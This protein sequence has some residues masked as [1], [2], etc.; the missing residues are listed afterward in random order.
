MMEIGNFCSDPTP[1]GKCFNEER[2]HFGMWCIVSSPLV[3]GFNMSDQDRMNRVWPIITNREAIAVDHAWA[4]L[5][6]TLFKTL[7]NDTLE[8]WSKPLPDQQVAVLVLNVGPGNVT[9]TLSVADDVPGKTKGAQYRSIWDKADVLIHGGTV[10]V[11][12]TSHDSL[13][14]VFSNSTVA[15]TVH[16]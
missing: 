6:G 10:P 1:S 15:P 3:L 5:P 9:T 12:L 7:L 16:E 13:F 2:S 11:S 14:A 4:G 8:V